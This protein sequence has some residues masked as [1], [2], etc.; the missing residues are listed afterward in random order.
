[1]LSTTVLRAMQ[2]KTRDAP[3]SLAERLKKIGSI[4]CILLYAEQQELALIAGG[5]ANTDFGKRLDGFLIKH[6]PVRQQSHAM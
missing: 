6:T 2:V 5:D 4:S 1:M 3:T